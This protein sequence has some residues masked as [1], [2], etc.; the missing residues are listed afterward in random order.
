[1]SLI[2]LTTYLRLLFPFPPVSLRLPEGKP[3]EERIIPEVPPSGLSADWER[4]QWGCLEWIL[5][6]NDS[7]Q[8]R[9]TL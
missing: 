8:T 4:V 3:A 9:R 7:F 5:T 2:A 1:M 6:R